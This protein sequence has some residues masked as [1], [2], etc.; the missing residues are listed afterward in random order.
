MTVIASCRSVAYAT[1]R[2]QS[3]LTAS[4]MTS[5]V[6]NRDRQ[7][8]SHQFSVPKPGRH[9][10]TLSPMTEHD[11]SREV[12]RHQFARL[13]AE[14]GVDGL[15]RPLR[16]DF[17]R[18]L[19][20]LVDRRPDVAFDHVFQLKASQVKRRGCFAFEAVPCEFSLAA[21]DWAPVGSK[22]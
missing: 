10:L 21:F 2:Q 17:R 14:Q 6:P 19:I 3:V 8:Q 15:R 12:L 1:G 4:P 22:T 16:R 13:C 5:Q 7:C 18:P 20:R 9:R 11:G